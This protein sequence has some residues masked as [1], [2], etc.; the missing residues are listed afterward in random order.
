MRVWH[1]LTHTSGLTYGFHRVHTV[2]AIYRAAGSD[3][4]APKGMDLAQAC[5]AWAALPLLFQPGAEWNYGVSTDVL[6]R[7]VEVAS[8]QSLDAFFADRILGP[9][10]MT[11]TSFWV[12]DDRASRLSALYRLR[13]GRT[14][15]RLGAPWEAARVKPVRL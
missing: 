6:G 5:D 1:L 7:V 2:D 4:G 11:D 14:V 13:P 10:G 15:V 12:A 9:L 8:G 3:P